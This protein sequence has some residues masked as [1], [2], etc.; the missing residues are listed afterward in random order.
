[1]QRAI[2]PDGSGAQGCASP[3]DCVRLTMLAYRRIKSR[4]GGPQASRNASPSMACAASPPAQPSRQQSFQAAYQVRRKLPA[5]IRK[6]FPQLRR[7]RNVEFG[8]R[9]QCPGDVSEH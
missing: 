2:Y 7:K 9:F 3:P 6:L 8:S 1:M 4:S 5:E